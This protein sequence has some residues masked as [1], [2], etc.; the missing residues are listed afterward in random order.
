MMRWLKAQF[1]S[2]ERARRAVLTVAMVLG[3]VGFC[4]SAGALLFAR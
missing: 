2:Q 4:V 3:T 1:A